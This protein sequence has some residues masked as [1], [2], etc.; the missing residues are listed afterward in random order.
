MKSIL[1]LIA[2][3]VL[4]ILTSGCSWRNYEG[5]GVYPT[6]TKPEYAYTDPVNY[7]GK[8]NVS[9]KWWEYKKDEFSFFDY[10]RGSYRGNA[11]WWAYAKA[12]VV[13]PIQITG[14][15]IYVLLGGEMP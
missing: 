7:N 9:Q 5:C 14:L 6:D 2:L 10:D 8:H 1:C 12:V 15:M 11:P 13:D 3:S 4:V